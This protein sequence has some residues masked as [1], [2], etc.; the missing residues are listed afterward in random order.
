MLQ[1]AYNATE[2]PVMLQEGIRVDFQGENDVLKVGRG[3]W[4]LNQMARGWFEPLAK[5]KTSQRSA[6]H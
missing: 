4:K 3:G 2:G 1:E 5:L 6:L